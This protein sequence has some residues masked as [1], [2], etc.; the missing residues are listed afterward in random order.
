MERRNS[1]NCWRPL[2]LNDGG[3][4]LSWPRGHGN[5]D[6]GQ[7]LVPRTSELEV[8]SERYRHACACANIDYARPVV[9]P[10]P[11]LAVS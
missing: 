4:G 3:F 10:A 6:G 11:H 2:A 9:L 8:S 1:G 7:G 5:G